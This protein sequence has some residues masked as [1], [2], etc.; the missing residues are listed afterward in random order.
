L[1]VPLVVPEATISSLGT[2]N[3]QQL[4]TRHFTNLSVAARETSDSRVFDSVSNVLFL[5]SMSELYLGTC[6][7]W[8]RSSE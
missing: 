3:S 8:S 2:Q 7:M 5:V 4:S 1:R 6:E